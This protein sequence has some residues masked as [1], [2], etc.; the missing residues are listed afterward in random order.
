M[1]ERIKIIAPGEATN[2]YEKRE[3]AFSRMFT[4]YNRP[5]CLC[6]PGSSAKE[7]RVEGGTPDLASLTRKRRAGRSSGREQPIS[8][9]CEI[10]RQSAADS[11]GSPCREWSSSSSFLFLLRR[12][13]H[14]LVRELEDSKAC[15]KIVPPLVSFFLLVHR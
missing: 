11:L 12:L 9:R 3:R 10:D 2:L 5:V 13:P 15:F 8:G 14:Y 4:R 7:T 6:P 1:G